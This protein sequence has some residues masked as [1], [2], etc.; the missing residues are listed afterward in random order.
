MTDLRARVRR[1]LA[2]F[3]GP[4]AVLVLYAI[5]RVVHA[6][7]AGGRGI[8]TPSGDID[9]TLVALGFATFI[10]RL[11]AII[12]VPPVVVYRLVMRAAQR[13]TRDEPPSP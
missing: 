8:L 13:W 5:M 10:L 3:V 6:A 1:E 9:G 12:V 2:P 11:L 7:V 4:A